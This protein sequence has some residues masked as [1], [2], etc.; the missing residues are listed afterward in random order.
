MRLITAL[1]TA[2]LAVFVL[3]SP[4]QATDDVVNDTPPRLAEPVMCVHPDFPVLGSGWK[5]QAAVRAWNDAQSIIRLTTALEPGCA[6][7]YV[8][9]YSA[10]DGR[11]AFTEWDRVWYQG[12]YAPDGKGW[13]VEGADIYLNDLCVVGFTKWFSRWTVAHEL[14]HAMGLVHN[15]SP[16]SAMSTNPI[17]TYWRRPVV[18]PVDVRDLALLYRS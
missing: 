7:V 5:V 14:G 8:H 17:F 9:R 4:A 12:H 18:A 6:T 16:R 11:C 10:Y 1:L 3:G 13:M 15:T 2:V